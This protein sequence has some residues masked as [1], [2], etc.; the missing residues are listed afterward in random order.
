L[1]FITGKINEEFSNY[2]ANAL[3]ENESELTSLPF[4]VLARLSLFSVYLTINEEEDELKQHLYATMFMNAMILAKG[5]WDNLSNDSVIK[6]I[7]KYHIA[8]YLSNHDTIGDEIKSSIISNIADD[9]KY[10]KEH[11]FDDVELSDLQTLAKDAACYRCEKLLSN[12]KFIDISDPFIRVYSFITE[13]VESYK[14]LYYDYNILV[15]I[16]NCIKGDQKSKMFSN[17]L[18]ELAAYTKPLNT[19][20]SVILRLLQNDKIEDSDLLLQKRLK[21]N[22]FAIYLYYELLVERMI[23]N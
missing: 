5:R 2:V 11:E 13:L 12:K 3:N 4:N 21:V 9:H 7:Y 8:N 19:D 16:T 22:E 20:T 14:Y 10:Y 23:E 6:D 15:Y 17:I 18:K 1:S